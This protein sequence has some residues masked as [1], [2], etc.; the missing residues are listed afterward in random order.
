M[1]AINYRPEEGYTSSWGP[2][3][4]SIVDLV[5]PDNSRM[6]LPTGQSGHPFS[7]HYRDQ[8][9]LYNTGQYRAVDF[10]REAVVRAAVSTLILQP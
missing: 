9:E 10:T 7:D 3:Q 6:V 4:R 8:A 1:N 2:S 5:D